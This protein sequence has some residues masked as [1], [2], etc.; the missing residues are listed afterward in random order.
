M[1]RPSARSGYTLL[2]V[3]LVM[4]IMVSLLA[5]AGPTMTAMYG[6]IRVKAAADQVREAWTDCRAYS[7]DE[8]RAYRFAVQPNTGKF[9]LAPDAAEF[10]GGS[11]G[12]TSYGSDDAALP[13]HIKEGE[14]NGGIQFNVAEGIGETSGDGWTSV[15]IFLPDGT[16]DADREVT[17]QGNDDSRPILIR[18]RA[19]TGAVSVRNAPING[20]K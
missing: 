4:T 10:W 7:I 18:L 8:G 5:I 2:E 11:A 6:D 1:T 17:L 19:M 20:G 12:A 9:R 3:L 13:P 15:A 16:G 14:L